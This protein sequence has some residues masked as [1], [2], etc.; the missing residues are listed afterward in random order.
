LKTKIILF[1]YNIMKG[2]NTDS[3]AGEVQGFDYDNVER[4]GSV[5]MT[6]GKGKGKGKKNSSKF[7]DFDFEKEWKEFEQSYNQ[8]YG[9]A[10]KK[11][12]TSSS[13]KKKPAKKASS[14]A[15][16]PAKKG[17]KKPTKRK[18]QRGGDEAGATFAPAQMFDEKATMSAPPAGPFQSA[19]GTIKAVDGLDRNLAPYPNATETQTGGAK[20][21]KA[22][23]AKKPKTAT[24]TTKPKKDTK[25]KDSKKDAK[26][27]SKKDTKS[28]GKKV[29]VLDKIK[30]FFAM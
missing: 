11:R 16:K 14:S 1:A 29:S 27:D 20:K 4:Y 10:S 26:K 12:K 30:K 17:A 24:K 22:S 9:G 23:K 28:T 8:K 13:T 15:K 2:G 18:T 21:K 6:G 3:K 5:D 7:S 25:K 19:Y